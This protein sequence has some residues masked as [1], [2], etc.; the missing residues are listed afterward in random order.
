[1]A[2]FPEIYVLRHG[3]T[4]WNAQ[5]RLQGMLNAPLTPLGRAQA[6]RQAVIL[7]QVDLSGLRVLCSPQG[8]AVETAAIAVAGQVPQIHTD[9]GLREIGVGDWAGA[10]RQDLI[11]SKQIS[12]A[13]ARNLMLYDRA[14][15]GEGL[16]ALERRCRCFLETLQGPAILITHGITSRMIRAIATGQGRDAA[17][18]IGGGQGVVYHVKNSVQKRLE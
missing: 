8:R 3:E 4:E 12:E 7:Q 5:D 14:P 18:E 10:Y 1:M 9:V 6:Q 11:D 13:E 16:T 2:S 17:G 15:N